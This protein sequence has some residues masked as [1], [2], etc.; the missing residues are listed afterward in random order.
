MCNSVVF[1]FSRDVTKYVV[2]VQKFTVICV[3][4]VCGPLPL[5]NMLSLDCHLQPSSSR[6]SFVNQSMTR[7]HTSPLSLR[8]LFALRRPAS[9][10]MYALP[11]I[12]YALP[13]IFLAAFKSLPMVLLPCSI[14]LGLYHQNGRVNIHYD[15]HFT[16]LLQLNDSVRT[17]HAHY[18][19]RHA[20]FSIYYPSPNPAWHLPRSVLKSFR[21]S[22]TASSGFSQ[23]CHNQPCK[24]CWIDC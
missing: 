18:L 2:R 23:C 24:S 5:S 4:W 13:C 19:P 22:V 8:S 14:S 10:P 6:P 3:C 7:I 15:I 1:H 9:L 21:Y 11:W 20:D 16:T 12:L 17:P